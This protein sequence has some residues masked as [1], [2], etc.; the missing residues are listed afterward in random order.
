MLENHSYMLVLLGY[1]G[2]EW[3]NPIPCFLE[4]IQEQDSRLKIQES[5]K[6]SIPVA[7]IVFKKLS[8]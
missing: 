4:L 2:Y 7:K 8:T 1:Q 5:R 3:W 6:D